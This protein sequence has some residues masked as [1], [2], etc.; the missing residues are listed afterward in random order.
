MSITEDKFLATL[1]HELRN[2]LAPIFNAL[3][4]LR[5]AGDQPDVL[6][7][8]RA[9]IDRQLRRLIR[10]ADDLLDVSKISSGTIQLRK[11]R[12]ELVPL[13]TDA[14]ADIRTTIDRA[15]QNLA[16]SLPETPLWLTADPTRLSQVVFNLLSNAT[17]YTK[18]GGH[19][20]VK[21]ERDG[22]SVLICVE[23]E[24]V[25]IPSEELKNVF[26]IFAKLPSSPDSSRSGLGIGLSLARSLVSLHGGTI[27]ATSDGPGRGS[28][29]TIRLPLETAAERTN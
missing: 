28:V 9:V 23:D 29:F 3:E 14:I 24:G 17:Q 22:A 12:V 5:L 4:I 10:I 11:Q 8:Q 26:K 27:D 13:I 6:E 1:S 20:A 18:P 16:V 21:V 2:P 19:I 7:S 25:G 15:E